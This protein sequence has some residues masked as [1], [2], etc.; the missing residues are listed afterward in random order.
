MNINFLDVIL[1][2]VLS[3]FAIRGL[4]NGF[5]AEVLDVIA[6]IGGLYLA[7]TFYVYV[8]SYIDFISN[9]LWKNLI[10]YISIFI[11]VNICIMILHRILQKIISFSF[12]GWIDSLGGIIVGIAKGILL[13][14]IMLMLVNTFAPDTSY[15]QQSYVVPYLEELLM[16]ARNYI[17]LELL[18]ELN[19]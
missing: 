8:A 1:L 9:P 16:Y 2:C 3:L 14:V 7:N 17:P 4:M 11:A 18:K 6:I 19:I 5:V 12:I 10:A 13:C 15:L